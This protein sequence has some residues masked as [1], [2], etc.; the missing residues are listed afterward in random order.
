MK[1]HHGYQNHHASDCPFNF[2]NPHNYREL[3]EEILLS[4]K[5]GGITNNKTV[6]AITS[7]GHVEDVDN[8]ESLLIGA[9][10]PSAVLGAGSE[11]KEDVSAPLTVKHLLWACSLV[12]LSIDEPTTVNSMLDC[13]AH[14]MLIDAAL[15]QSLGLRHFRLHKPLPISVALNNM[16]CSDSHLHEYVKIAPFAPDSSYVSCTIK[17]IVMPSLCVLLLLGLPFLVANHI[18]TDFVACTAINKQCNVDLLNA[19]L[20]V[21]NRKFTEPV[22]SMVDVK[23]EKKV[24]LQELI[25][26]C[27]ECLK[28]G[29]GTLEFVKPLNIAVMIKDQIEVLA[30]KEKFG[31]LKKNFLSEF[32]DVFEPLPHVGK[33]P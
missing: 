29:K 10:M 9:V 24:M 22:M 25:I 16:I 18:V 5:C 28:N 12:G 30:L 20:K 7:P 1:C 26:V 33:L 27:K 13:G 2:P 11:S 21:K 14:I 15:V 23:K 6:G 32:K 17:A 31:S 4:Q 8:V 19:P 3:T